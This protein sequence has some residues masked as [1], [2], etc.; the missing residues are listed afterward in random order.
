MT[1]A[2]LDFRRPLS[3]RTAQL[4]SIAQEESG[5]EAAALDITA[6]L[7]PLL[8]ARAQQLLSALSQQQMQ[9]SWCKF[10]S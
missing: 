1:M 3:A 2:Q 5:E 9:C 10:S 8:P 7:E 4:V 6:T